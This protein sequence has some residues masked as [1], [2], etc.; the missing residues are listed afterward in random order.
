ML[1]ER[2]VDGSSGAND[3]GHFTW[4]DDMSLAEEFLENHRSVKIV[5]AINTHSADNGYFVWT[6]STAETFC[7]CSLLEVT[8]FA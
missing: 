6:G 2:S 5:V 4:S 3:D 1:A 7:A 8:M